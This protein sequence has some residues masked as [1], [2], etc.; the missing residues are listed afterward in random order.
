MV[1]CRVTVAIIGTINF[2][3]FI[4]L[5]SLYS[6]LIAAFAICLLRS[7]LGCM[8]SLLLAIVALGELELGGVLLSRIES[9][10]V[11]DTLL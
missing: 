8:V 5:A 1:P 4:L 2:I 3:Y 10:V 9:V 7:A 11:M 6:M